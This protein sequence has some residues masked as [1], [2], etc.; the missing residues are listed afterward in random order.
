[1]VSETA[2]AGTVKLFSVM[3]ER[4]RYDVGWLLTD[5]AVT[6]PMIAAPWPP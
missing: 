4:K 5:C 2:P 1:M 3:L 6:M